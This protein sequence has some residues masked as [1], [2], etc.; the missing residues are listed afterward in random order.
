VY[1]KIASD[2]W[3]HELQAAFDVTDLGRNLT[4]EGKTPA[5]H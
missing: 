2:L 4:S 3:R 1:K 5:V